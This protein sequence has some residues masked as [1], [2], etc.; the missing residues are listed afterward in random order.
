MAHSALEVT[1]VALAVTNVVSTTVWV[2]EVTFVAQRTRGQ[3]RRPTALSAVF[4]EI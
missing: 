1:F 2:V 3:S 4:A